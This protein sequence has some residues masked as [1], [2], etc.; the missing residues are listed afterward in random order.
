MGRILTE[1]DT[2]LAP[3]GGTLKHALP[4]HAAQRAEYFFLFL[5]F[6]K[7]L[8]DRLQSMHGL[9]FGN[10]DGVDTSRASH[11]I[12]RG[13]RSGET[14]HYDFL[15]KDASVVEQTATACGRTDAAHYCNLGI[16]PGF[17]AE[18]N[19]FATPE[20]DRVAFDLRLLLEVHAGAT[21][22]L[23]QRVNI[24]P[25]RI[26]D[27]VHG[28]LAIGLLD[29]GPP[30]TAANYRTY[31]E[32]AQARMTTYR[33][34]RRKEKLLGVAACCDLYLDFYRNGP[35]CRSPYDRD[36]LWKIV[37]GKAEAECGGLGLDRSLYLAMTVH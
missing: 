7:A 33:D 31:C 3:L 29:G 12:A 25:D 6:Y 17:L 32:T 2:R 18:A 1:A 36:G 30:L 5:F 19:V 23:P 4:M 8:S 22:M 28:T 14:A 11:Q 27:Q 24:G 9:A 26:V 15:D 10:A 35:G 37:T 13:M 20:T 16:K 34:E 21:R